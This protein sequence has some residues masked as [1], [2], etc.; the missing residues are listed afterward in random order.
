MQLYGKN[1]VLF[2]KIKAMKKKMIFY[3]TECM[4]ESVKYRIAQ[5]S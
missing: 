4:N 1:D 5:L 3:E 2:A